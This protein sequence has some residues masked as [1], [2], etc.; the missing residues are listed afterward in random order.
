MFVVAV[1]DVIVKRNYSVF[2]D[3]MGCDAAILQANFDVAQKMVSFACKS[4][5]TG[6][7]AVSSSQHLSRIPVLSLFTVIERPREGNNKLKR[8]EVAFRKD[9]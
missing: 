1:A 3:A 4:A 9:L 7:E 6:L 5:R 8:R 2:E